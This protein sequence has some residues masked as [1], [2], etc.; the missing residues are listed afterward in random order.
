MSQDGESV[1]PFAPGDQIEHMVLA[2]SFTLPDLSDDEEDSKPLSAKIRG[3]EPLI[4][5]RS[6]RA[7]ARTTGG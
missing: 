1:Q 5:G 6:V 2:D 3:A 7:A 4:A